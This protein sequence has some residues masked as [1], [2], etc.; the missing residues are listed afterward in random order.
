MVNSENWDW[1]CKENLVADT[2][3]WKSQIEVIEIPE[4]LQP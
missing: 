4:D 3:K 2:S 1:E